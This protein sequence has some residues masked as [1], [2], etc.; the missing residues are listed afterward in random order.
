MK[1]YDIRP[2]IKKEIEI[3]KK[4]S[5]KYW[6]LAEAFIKHSRYGIPLLA[7]FCLFL[8]GAFISAVTK[9]EIKTIRVLPQVVSGDWQ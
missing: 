5:L 6:R 2:P 4:I 1:I 3:A 8:A 9:P 7:V